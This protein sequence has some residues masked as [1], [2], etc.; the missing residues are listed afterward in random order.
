M[1]HTTT[2]L[3]D[4]ARALV[5]QLLRTGMLLLDIV[6]GLLVD[7]PADA[8]PGEDPATVLVEMIAGSAA[9]AVAAAGPATV[10][11]AC[12][13]VGAVGDRTIA[14]LRTAMAAT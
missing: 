4:A 10:A 8:F 9:P 3:S 6:D 11:A 13:L 5:E 1:D 2:P 7:L 14:D 12:A